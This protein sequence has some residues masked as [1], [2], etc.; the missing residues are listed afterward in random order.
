MIE[1]LCIDGKLKKIDYQNYI[2]SQAMEQAMSLLKKILD[3]KGQITLAEYR[4]AIGTSRKYAMMLLEYA[5]REKLTK[6]TGDV[7]VRYQ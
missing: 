4:D 1:G 3:E 2:H 7:R 6:K 5:D